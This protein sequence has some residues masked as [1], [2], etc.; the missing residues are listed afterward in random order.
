MKLRTIRRI[1]ALIFIMSITFL[2]VDITG[3]AHH[4][5][6]WM[7]KVQ[8]LPAALALNVVVIAALAALTLLFGRIYCS[9]ICPLGV[10]QDVF[11]HFGRKTRKNRYTY[12]KAVGLLRYFMLAVLVTA[13]VLG[14]TAI[15]SLLDPYGHFGR[16]ASSV[17]QPI[18]QAGN[19]LLARVAESVDSYAFYKVDVWVKSLPVLLLSVATLATIAVLAWR[20][21]R[22]YCNTICPVGTVLGLLSRFSL[23]KV[24]FDTAKCKSCSMCTKNCK[25]ACIDYKN[26]SIDYSRCVVCGNCVNSCNF[27]AL[28][29]SVRR[30]TTV[31]QAATAHAAKD[32]GSTRKEATSAGIDS[33]RRTFLMASAMLTT[34]ALAQQTKKVDGGL[35]IIEDKVAPHRH[36]KISPP[37]SWSSRNVARHCTGCQLCVAQCPNGVLRPD[38]GMMTVMQPVMSYERG[39]CRPECTR[40]SQVCPTGAIRP[41]S[42]EEKASVQIGQA[43]WIKKNC[44]PVTDGVECGNCARHCP[45]GAIEMIPLDENNESSPF[46]PAVNETR[47][48]G[49]GACEN[50]CPARPFSAIYVEGYEEHHT[51]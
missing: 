45:S 38:T 35:A 33:S 47:C 4:W 44:I 27:G 30:R 20:N 13:V 10:L 36:T 40:C 34:S 2:F 26:H 17:L 48:I 42:K 50:L 9:V 6:G 22:T 8:M 21:G 14:F 49:C 15:V 46:V 39:Y 12:S 32:A 1:L 37:G 7:A 43:V 31:S 24:R 28:T 11:A 41:I 51:Y 25:A 18:Y 23:M 29:Y 19:N 16:M 3:V 5:L